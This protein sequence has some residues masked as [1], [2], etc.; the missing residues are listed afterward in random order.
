MTENIIMLMMIQD[1][2]EYENSLQE[3]PKWRNKRKAG[4]KTKN[5]ITPPQ[6]MSRLSLP[7]SAVQIFLLYSNFKLSNGMKIG[8]VTDMWSQKPNSEVTYRV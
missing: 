1:A 2:Q 6:H 8:V 5:K 3:N 4:D 7:Y